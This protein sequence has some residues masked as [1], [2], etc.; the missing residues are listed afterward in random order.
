MDDY[1]NKIQEIEATLHLLTFKLGKDDLKKFIDDTTDL[2]WYDVLMNEDKERIMTDELLKRA[3][4]LSQ[5]KLKDCLD[6]EYR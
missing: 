6:E 2:K 3:K 5:I 4:Y 1:E